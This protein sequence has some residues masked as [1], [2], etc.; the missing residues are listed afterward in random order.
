MQVISQDLTTAPFASIPLNVTA[1]VAQEV[2]NQDE[3]DSRSQKRK[4]YLVQGAD[5]PCFYSGHTPL[6][7]VRPS[8]IGLHR[9]DVQPSSVP[10]SSLRHKG[11]Q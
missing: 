4:S 10:R 5:V 7:P 8:I 6:S 9:L 1:I 3:M 2:L 11:K